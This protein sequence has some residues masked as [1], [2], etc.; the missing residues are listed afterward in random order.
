MDKLDTNHLNT[1][2]V[3]EPINDDILLNAEESEEDD[4]ER[5]EMNLEEREIINNMEINEENSENK[6]PSN[7]F[8]S[9]SLRSVG[10]R[11]DFRNIQIPKATSSE[12]TAARF[13]LVTLRYNANKAANAQSEVENESP[14]TAAN[15]EPTR[16]GRGGR[17]KGSKN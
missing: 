7:Q 16:R 14:E 3:V 1:Q 6:P 8:A 4:E 11:L 10:Q 13:P 15:V 5:Q 12:S 9:T 17:K 2:E